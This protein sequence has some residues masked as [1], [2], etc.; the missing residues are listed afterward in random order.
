MKKIL[1]LL[2]VAAVACA[3][4]SKNKNNAGEGAY[5]AQNAAY[6][7]KDARYAKGKDDKTIKDAKYQIIDQEFDNMLAPEKDYDNIPAYELQACGD[8]Y[9][10]LVDPDCCGKNKVAAKGKAKAKAK[11][12]AKS[13]STARAKKVTN[14]TNIYYVD[15]PNPNVPVSSTTTTKT[16]YSNGA[17]AS[18][19]TTSSNTKTTQNA[20]GSVT[21][22]TINY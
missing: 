18:S 8:S 10:P 9:L 12:V 14:T 17:V 22:T 21:T 20:D 16:V 11:G 1:C 13:V 15:G 2:A 4:C 19:T 7:N 6:R 3:A 5:G